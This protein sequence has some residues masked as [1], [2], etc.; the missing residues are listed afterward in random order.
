MPPFHVHFRH[1]MQMVV[2][3]VY[4]A[5]LTAK[6]RPQQLRAIK[7]ASSYFQGCMRGLG[8]HVSIEEYACFP[9]YEQTFPNI[10]LTHL[11]KD[12]EDLHKAEAAVS[13]AFEEALMRDYAD[14]LA[15]TAEMMELLHIVLEFDSHLMAHLGEE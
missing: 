9:L 4:E 1:E 10:D 2:Q 14:D 5:A 3:H 12:H 8:G 15:P 6:C 11:Y 7:R 13:E